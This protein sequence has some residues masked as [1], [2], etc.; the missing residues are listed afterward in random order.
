MIT[1]LRTC[2]SDSHSGEKSNQCDQCDYRCILAGRQFEEPCDHHTSHLLLGFMAEPIGHW[3]SLEK[4]GLFENGPFTLK[5][6]GLWAP[7]LI[8]LSRARGRYFEHQVFPALIQNICS[9]EYFVKPGSLGSSPFLFAQLWYALY[10]SFMPPLSAMFS[11]WVLIPLR[12]METGGL[13]V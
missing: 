10:A 8:L 7:V 3:K 6:P 13:A 11:P 12:L 1:R 9:G 4:S 5:G 2:C